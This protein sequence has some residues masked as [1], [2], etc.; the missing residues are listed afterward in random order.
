MNTPI[1]MHRICMALV[2]WISATGVIQGQAEL[3]GILNNELVTVNPNTG[4]ATAVQALNPVPPVPIRAITYFPE[5]CAFYGIGELEPNPNLYEILIDGTVRNLGRITSTS[6]SVNLVEGISYNPANQQLYIVAGIDIVPAPGNFFSRS[7][8]TVDPNT[9]A[10]TFVAN[11]N[12][13]QNTPEGDAILHFDDDLILFDADSRGISFSAFYQIMDADLL[14]GNQA[15]PFYTDNQ[16][17]LIRDLA[18]FDN[19]IYGTEANQLYRIDPLAANPT[20]EVVGTTHN[21]ATT[22]GATISALATYIIPPPDPVVIS[23]GADTTLCA[24]NTLVLVLPVEAGSIVTWNDG[25]TENPRT[26]MVTGDYSAMIESGNCVAFTDTITVTVPNLPPPVQLP[27]TDSSFCEAVVPF[28]LNV[29]PEND[30]LVTNVRWTTGQTGDSI[31]VLVPGTYQATYNY[32]SCPQESSI[33]TVRVIGSE[34]LEVALLGTL[35]LDEALQLEVLGQ[36]DSI[37]WNTGATTPLITIDSSGSF[38]VRTVVDGCEQISVP[39]TIDFSVCNNDLCDVY[40]PNAFSPNGD[41]L[42]D[43]FTIYFPEA[44]CT[45]ETYSIQIFDRWGELVHESTELEGWDGNLNGQ[46]MDPA[47]FVYLIEGT[48][49]NGL[50]ILPFSATGSLHLLR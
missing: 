17:R 1:S 32:D 5:R 37:Q 33:A 50:T 3:Y 24:E 43:R 25:N 47:V 27:F 34:P 35:C 30:P 44:I 36:F 11:L 7:I 19:I 12:T 28:T 4:A 14:A 45:L 8:L 6:G 10:A 16:F 21:P 26:I 22:D 42:N 2:F 49:N 40:V 9:A 23:L 41:N 39:T 31:T 48:L 18:V 15:T 29:N 46:P 38:F 13:D 20:L